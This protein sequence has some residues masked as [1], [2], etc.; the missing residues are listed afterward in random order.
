[1]T[2][3]QSLATSIRPFGPAGGQTD[4]P[5]QPASF[6]SRRVKLRLGP[7]RRALVAAQSLGKDAPQLGSGLSCQGHWMFVQQEPRRCS[8]LNGIVC[9]WPCAREARSRQRSGSTSL[10]RECTRLRSHCAR[11]LSP[12]V[13][14]CSGCHVRDSGRSAS[15]ATG[16]IVRRVLS[17]HQEPE[18]PRGRPSSR[19]QGVH[20]SFSPANPAASGVPGAD[21]VAT[22][23]G[24]DPDLDDVAAAQPTVDRQI[25]HR[26]VSDPSLTV[27]PEAD[28]PDLLRFERALRAELS[29]CG[30]RPSIAEP[31]IV[32]GM[33]LACLLPAKSGPG[34]RAPRE[35][36]REG[37]PVLAV[38]LACAGSLKR[39]SLFDLSRGRGRQAGRRVDTPGLRQ[40]PGR[41]PGGQ[42]TGHDRLSAVDALRRSPRPSRRRTA[43]VPPHNQPA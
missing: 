13:G 39:T 20:R 27:E 36:P 26:S 12:C 3:D 29:A 42:V 6:G 38:P 34:R 5:D 16:T 7:I 30:P 25:E 19:G 8:P 21:S 11:D 41:P 18:P 10:R 23:E 22:G 33:S 17:P 4:T 1:M 43:T 14:R 31:R 15:Q 37:W 28:G 40:L 32:L 35:R 9:S 2:P 24:A